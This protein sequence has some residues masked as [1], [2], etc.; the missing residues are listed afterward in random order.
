MKLHGLLI[1]KDDDLLV[2]DW[3]T[4]NH[5]TF[6]SIVV[7]DGSTTDI[8]RRCVE[9]YENTTYLR[10]P[11]SHITDQ[12]LRKHGW[13]ELRKTAELGD[14]IFICH[15]DEF[16]IHHPKTLMGVDGNVMFWLP[17]V[18]LPH[19]SEAPNWI[20][21]KDKRPRQLFRHYWW[22][23][24]QFPHCE[25]RMFRYVKEPIWNTETRR[26][27]CGVIPH[28]YYNETY[29][30]LAPLY[31]H[32]KCYN[33]SLSAYSDGGGFLR[34]QLTTGLP[35]PVK[36]FD[37]LFFYDERP[38]TD[39]YFAY[40]N[41]HSKILTRFGNPPR[42]VIDSNGQLMIVNNDGISVEHVT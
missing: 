3:F 30:A 39:G 1:T 38:F 22:R 19:P 7:V 12:T 18:I 33:L 37:D 20:V 36:D 31:Y 41:D 29:C 35:R 23:N 28:N 5:A 6:D 11:E 15:V 40:D 34:S 27:S 17:M 26:P 10:D 13:D 14:W 24:K 32:Y 21:S 42:I 9:R 16:Y 4:E 2:D 25:H 8:T